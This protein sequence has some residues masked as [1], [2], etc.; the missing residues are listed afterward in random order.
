MI[1]RALA[2]VIFGIG[3]NACATQGHEF[4]SDVSWIKA[5]ATKQ[6]QIRSVLGE[7]AQVGNSAGTV[8][9]TYGFY[10]YRLIG[11]SHTKELKLYWNPNLTVKTFSFSSS[12]P[13]DLMLTSATR[14]AVKSGPTKW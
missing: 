6:E 12:F 5:D 13:E 11:Q 4:P 8:T 3:L 7:P 9:W 14:P 1:K 10:K 2:S